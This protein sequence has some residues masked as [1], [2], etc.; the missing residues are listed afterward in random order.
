MNTEEQQ[1]LDLLRELV[2]KA[3]SQGF[4]DVRDNHKR[5]SVFGRQMRFDLSKGFPLYT[6]KKVF[7]RGAFE[8]LM[9]FL[10]GDT[11]NKTLMEKDVHIWDLW[12]DSL[13]EYGYEYGELGAI[14]GES[15][16]AFNKTFDGVGFDQIGYV[17]NEI[18]NNPSS[19]RLVVSSWNPKAHSTEGHS[20]L[21]P[22]HALYQF[23][24]E[25]GKLSCQLYQRSADM[26]IGQPINVVSYSL[27]THLIAQQCNL[28]V[29]EFVWTGG[30]CHIYNNQLDKVKE[31]VSRKTHKFPTI[32]INK[33]S[34]IE[35]YMW[36]DITI[37]NYV[38][39][40]KIIIPVA[41]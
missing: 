17:V 18:K 32:S 26:P 35:S 28:D 2:E 25:D 19:S 40:P 9:W 10:R 38:S 33:A 5:V 4:R 13:V 23:L 22:C 41:K 29:G 24:V 12:N 21:P 37:N 30:D 39:E 8:E 34:S 20:A 16:R 6:H 27:L 3:E 7:M 15:W 31:I 11:D 1:Y 36:S 14:Y